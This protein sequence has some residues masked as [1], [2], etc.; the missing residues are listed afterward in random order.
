MSTCKTIQDINQNLHRGCI[1]SNIFIL[2]AS[3]A[4]FYK[5]LPVLGVGI[6]IVFVVSMGK[7]CRD[8]DRRFGLADR[9][10]SIILCVLFFA[11]VAWGLLK[12][13]FAINP[14]MVLSMVLA[15]ISLGFLMVARYERKLKRDTNCGV[16]K[17]NTLYLYYHTIW[18]ILGGITAT[19]FI[20][21][22]P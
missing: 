21:S 8:T 9:I 15:I 3:L 13:K 16:D 18:H 11:Y 20:L 14:T 1:W 5:K 2:G 4:A 22:L 10:V 19:Y 12:R 17:G 6:I 7:H